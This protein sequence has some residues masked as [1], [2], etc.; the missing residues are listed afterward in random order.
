LAQAEAAQ[1]LGPAAFQI[2][3][4][5][6]AAVDRFARKH[7]L[8]R[9]QSIRY[10]VCFYLEN[11]EDRPLT[12]LQTFQIVLPPPE[13]RRRNRLMAAARTAI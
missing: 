12:P 13:R 1:R 11:H 5:E 4:E 2:A 10:A 6:L 7:S 3:P 9:A 8:S